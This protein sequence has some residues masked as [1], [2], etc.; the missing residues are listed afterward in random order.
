MAG[1]KK[2]LTAS[3]HPIAVSPSPCINNTLAVC[4][5]GSLSSPPRG[6][7]ST[8]CVGAC[9]PSTSMVLMSATWEGPSTVHAAVLEWNPLLL[10]GGLQLNAAAPPCLPPPLRHT[11]ATRDNKCSS[12]RSAMVW[13]ML[14]CVL[15]V[16][17]NPMLAL[18]RESCSTTTCTRDQHGNTC[19]R[20][21]KWWRWRREGW[22]DSHRHKQA[23]EE[24]DKQDK[25]LTRPDSECQCRHS[26]ARGQW[27]DQPW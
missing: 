2:P 13:L 9:R 8:T 3:V 4:W 25:D 26:W 17:D 12:C 22:S 1:A 21:W 15:Y 23:T 7:N 27:Q 19:R 6:T 20:S 5:V 16:C 14:C 24:E 10:T 18:A 11:T